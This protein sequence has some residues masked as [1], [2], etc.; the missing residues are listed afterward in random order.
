[1]SENAQTTNEL[2]S[3]IVLMRVE[4]EQLRA[5][6]KQLSNDLKFTRLK[7]QYVLG[8]MFGKKSEK[9]DPNQLLLPLEGEIAPQIP[10]KKKSEPSPQPRKS[11]KRKQ[12]KNRLPEDLPLE[13]VFID[14]DEVMR[15][16]DDYRCIG[17]E[18][19]EELEVSPTRFYRR[20]IIRRK[21]V[22]RSDR[23][24]APIIVPAPERLIPRSFA[25][26]SLLVYILISKYVDHLPLYRQERIFKSRYGIELSR[27]TMS[28]WMWS[29]ANWLRLV[30]GE[31]KNEIFETGYLQVDETFI[32]Y[33]KPGS[34]CAQQGYL[35]TYHAPGAGVVFDWQTGRSTACLESMLKDYEGSIQTDGYQ[36]YQTYN[37]KRRSEGQEPLD[38]FACWAHARRYFIK[39]EEESYFSQWMIRQIQLLY[40]IEKKLRD[41]NSGP[42]L[43]MAVRQAESVM[44]LNRIERALKLK[45]FKHLPKSLTGKAIAYTL[46]L[47]EQLAHYTDDGRVEIDNNLVEN[48]IRPTAIG[49]KN[50]LFFGSE[51]AGWQSAVIYS[52]VETC[53]KLGINPQE[54]LLDILPRLPHIT[55]HQARELTPKKWLLARLKTTC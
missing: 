30:Y 45:Q 29:I 14:P 47:L 13:T 44:V 40:Q 53:R 9:V 27:K 11:R 42:A 33:L 36:V 31:M 23:E 41:T 18:I 48:T 54:Y 1:M 5:E 49:K 21:Y 7:L 25:T 52:I 50:W 39:A 22:K 6:N 10:P 28:G 43:R 34:G 8:R 2:Q 16:P 26:A 35:W 51:T 3:Q 38:L 17:E 20:R 32:K 46:N 15:N 4:L 19:L 24:Q 12:H 37:R 55:N